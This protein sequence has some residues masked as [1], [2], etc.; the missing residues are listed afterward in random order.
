[1]ERL[2]KL[3]VRTA[4]AFTIFIISVCAGAYIASGDPQEASE[5]SSFFAIEGGIRYETIFQALAATFSV[6]LINLVLE[7]PAVFKNVL[8]LWKTVIRLILSVLITLC[9][10]LYYDWFPI[11]NIAAWVSFF[12]S[13]M[14]CIG[15]GTLMMVIKTR[16]EDALYQK[17]FEEYKQK[18]KGD[19]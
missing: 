5:L 14:L 6:S 7:E 16:R 3:G 11:H 8:M 13:F 9:F 18:H 15:A 12:V 2:M 1:M 4:V 17:L 10:A 19:N